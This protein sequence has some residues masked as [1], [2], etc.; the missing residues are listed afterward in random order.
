MRGFYYSSFRRCGL[1]FFVLQKDNKI[2]VHNLS[3]HKKLEQS[4]NWNIFKKW[5]KDFTFGSGCTVR[6][7]CNSAVDFTG[8]NVVSVVAIFKIEVARDFYVTKQRIMHFLGCFSTSRELEES[9][10]RCATV[11]CIAARNQTFASFLSLK[12]RVLPLHADLP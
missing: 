3:I 9:L 4:T 1:N 10:L 2:L 8:K 5:G 12:L 11:A 6:A 7:C